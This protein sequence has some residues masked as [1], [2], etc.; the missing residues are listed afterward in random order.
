LYYQHLYKLKNDTPLPALDTK[1]GGVYSM[2]YVEGS[3]PQTVVLLTP[4][5]AAYETKCKFSLSSHT[6]SDF[7]LAR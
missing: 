4:Y 3:Y 7:S 5:I 2:W 6:F 1:V